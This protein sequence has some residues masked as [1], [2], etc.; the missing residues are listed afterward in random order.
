MYQ[1]HGSL[2]EFLL[3][4]ELV[5]DHAHID[6]ISHVGAGIPPDVVRINADFLQHP[7]HLGLIR[8][9]GFRARRKGSSGRGIN[10]GVLWNVF[11][12]EGERV[13]DLEDSVD[14]HSNERTSR[15]RGE[16]LGA[17]LDDLH[18]HLFS[19]SVQPICWIGLRWKFTKPSTWTDLRGIS[20]LLVVSV[21]RKG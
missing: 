2:V 14:V 17:V 18:D 12:G 8:G 20:F 1:R 4:E 5:L 3:V 11:S 16:G 7:D 10:V 9:V 19:L 15:G 13:G 6:K 21:S